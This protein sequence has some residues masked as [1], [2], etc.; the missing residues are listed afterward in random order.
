VPRGTQYT[1]TAVQVGFWV[2]ADI[3]EAKGPSL[4]TSRPPQRGHWGMHRTQLW[5]LKLR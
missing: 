1:A 2:V 5:P 3:G 4:A